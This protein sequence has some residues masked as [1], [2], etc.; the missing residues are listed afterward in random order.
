MNKPIKK[1][2]I[3][4]LDQLELLAIQDF[5]SFYTKIWRD[6]FQVCE[7][8]MVQRYTESKILP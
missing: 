4:M 8:S 7:K 1:L 6:F 2:A 3:A 5:L